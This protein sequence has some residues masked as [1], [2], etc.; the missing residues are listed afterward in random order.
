VSFGAGS[1]LDLIRLIFPQGRWGRNQI[2][3]AG[4][5]HASMFLDFY[6][7][8]TPSEPERFLN[9]WSATKITAAVCADAAR[10]GRPSHIQLVAASGG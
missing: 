7:A 1:G 3:L 4:Q 5:G 6:P 9:K 2:G 8:S 10:K